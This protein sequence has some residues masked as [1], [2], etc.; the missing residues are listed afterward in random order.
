MSM[1]NIVMMYLIHHHHLLNTY[2]IH[3]KYLKIDPYSFVNMIWSHI[4]LLP[5]MGPW[6]IT[7]NNHPFILINKEKEEK[8]DFHHSLCLKEA[9]AV[10]LFTLDLGLIEGMNHFLININGLV[11]RRVLIVLGI[12]KEHHQYYHG[13]VMLWDLIQL[14]E[15]KGIA[16]NEKALQEV[17]IH[18]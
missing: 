3:R 6:N 18:F 14:K 9:I 16:T 5:I 2:G 7:I 15:V 10:V 13:M 12:W 8:G 17:L 4:L 11:D 1:L